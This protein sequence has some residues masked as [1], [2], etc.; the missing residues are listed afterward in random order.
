LNVSHDQ[1]KD[2]TVE[3]AARKFSNND[4]S[5]QK[6]R[7]AERPGRRGSNAGEQALTLYQALPSC[8]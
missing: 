7:P 5:E 1:R 6:V 4:L 8:E 3:N 2:G